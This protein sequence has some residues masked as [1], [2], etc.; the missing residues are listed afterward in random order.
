L[1][2]LIFVFQPQSYS[3][4][5]KG[6]KKY[7]WGPQKEILHDKNKARIIR[8]FRRQ[9]MDRKTSGHK[10]QICPLGCGV[11]EGFPDINTK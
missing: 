1:T 4:L 10:L 3:K 5:W 7:S 8:T 2:L 11:R 9:L 6:C